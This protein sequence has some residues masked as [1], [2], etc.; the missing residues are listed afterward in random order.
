MKYYNRDYILRIWVDIKYF[1]ENIIKETIANV[2]LECDFK[3]LIEGIGI[4]YALIF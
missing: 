4:S 1:V 3:T 2:K